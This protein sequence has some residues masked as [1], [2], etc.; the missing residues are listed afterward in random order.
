MI[1]KTQSLILLFLLPILTCL[2]Q[3][4]NKS[5]YSNLP[6]VRLKTSN[7]YDRCRPCILE[8]YDKNN[9]LIRKAV[10]Y[11]DCIAGFYKEYYPNGQ[12]KVNGQTKEN[13]SGNWKNAYERGMCMNKTG[14]WTYYSEDGVL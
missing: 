4:I 2:G 14:E 7:D 11:T 12:I 9:K 8:T 5:I 10:Q 3:E 6:V 13:A 1:P